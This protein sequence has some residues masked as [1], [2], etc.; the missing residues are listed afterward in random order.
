MRDQE[1]ISYAVA[2][3]DTIPTTRWRRHRFPNRVVRINCAGEEQQVSFATAQMRDAF[4]LA[5]KNFVPPVMRK[6][7]QGPYGSH[8][9]HRHPGNK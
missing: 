9:R 5:Q 8:P 6:R 2:D 3:P 1:R 4:L 7:K